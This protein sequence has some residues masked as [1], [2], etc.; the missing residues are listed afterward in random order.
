MADV[1]QHFKKLPDERA[2]CLKCPQILLCKGASTSGLWWPE[3]TPVPAK[4]PKLSVNSTVKQSSLDPFLKRSS[5]R[6]IVA[7]LAALDGISI[8]AITKSKFIRESVSARGFKLPTS[9][10]TIIK[11]IHEFYDEIKNQTKKEFH[12]RIVEKKEL[13]S[14]T[15]DDWTSSANKRYLNINVHFADGSCYNLGL[16]RIHGSFPAEKIAHAIEQV[17]K[18]FGID[19]GS[20]TA[21]T[22]GAASVMVKFGKI[23]PYFHQLC[24][25]HALHLAVQDV[26][27]QMNSN[28]SESTASEEHSSSEIQDFDDED[29]DNEDRHDYSDNEKFYSSGTL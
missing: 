11:L 17:T 26:I 12:D 6:E 5:L 8:A 22:P 29:S 9:K 24:Y 23:V 3:P 4:Q 2:Q 27:N 28:E 21:V 7:R 25:N 18:D 19:I 10:S 13:V 1:W 15:T 14:L 20:I 16:S